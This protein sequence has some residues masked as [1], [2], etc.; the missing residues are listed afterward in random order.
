MASKAFSP[1]SD[2][3]KW[4]ESMIDWEVVLDHRSLTVQPKSNKCWTVDER[5]VR[6][7]SMSIIPLA[8]PPLFLYCVLNRQPGVPT[9]HNYLAGGR[10]Q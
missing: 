7:T 9:I 8:C 5:A 4:D 3:G 10:T 6:T 1:G 2:R